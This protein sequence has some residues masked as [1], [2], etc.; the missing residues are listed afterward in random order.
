MGI[1]PM[2]DSRAGWN[3]RTVSIAFLALLGFFVGCTTTRPDIPEAALRGRADAA[4]RL[5]RELTT[6][7]GSGE[8]LSPSFTERLLTAYRQ[9]AGATISSSQVQWVKG[10]ADYEARVSQ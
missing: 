7:H 3:M 1:L 8:A 4:D 9:A 2:S 6:L 5:V 10:V